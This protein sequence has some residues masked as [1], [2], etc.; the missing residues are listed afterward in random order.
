ML[1]VTRPWPQRIASPTLWALGCGISGFVADVL[2]VLDQLTE[3]V[4]DVRQYFTWLPAAIACV[5][6]VQFLTLIPVALALRGWL[7]PTR[8]V[9]LA[10]A[11]GIGAMLA[12]PT[13]QV[14]GLIG[15]LEFDVWV[16]LV[17]ATFL[18]VSTWV[19]TVSFTGHRHGTLSRPPPASDLC[20]GRHIQ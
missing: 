17:M 2:L 5:M 11:M 9:R 13:L 10:T 7:P 8:S 14:L 18:L 20:S 19:L 4:G 15:V 12:V 16:V 3:N 1:I 6:V